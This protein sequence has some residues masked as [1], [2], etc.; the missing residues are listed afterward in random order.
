MDN[1]ECKVRPDVMNCEDICTMVPALAGHRKLVEGVMRF[2]GLDEVNRI[3]GKYCHDTG[4]E[5]ATHL[6]D[7]EFRFRLRVDNEEVLSRYPEGPFITVSNH[8][9]G[10]MDGIILLHLVGR[11]RP[12][13]KVMVNLILDK[14]SA[15]KPSF[16]AV[17]PIPG[18]DPEK[19]KITMHG[20]REAMQHVRGGHPLGFFPAGAVSKINRSLRIR[21]RLWQPS[22]IRLIQ[23]LKVPVIP[24][25]FHGHN[26][27]FF[28]VLGL[29]DWRLRS[30]RLP[31]ELYR[32]RDKEIHIT[33]GNPIGPEEQARCGDTESLGRFLRERTYSLS[34]QR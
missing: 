27:T 30:L 13:F 18:D 10:A 34:K 14:I 22:V 23:Q 32:M 16:I 19:K 31:K 33:V 12:D 3:H 9:F 7:D 20:I 5:F 21:D 15:M 2:I 8:P 24:V 29:I 1:K 28:N 6:V 26:S 11:Y 4:V 25:Y 17:N